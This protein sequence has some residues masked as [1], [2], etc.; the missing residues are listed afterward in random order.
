MPLLGQHIPALGVIAAYDHEDADCKADLVGLAQAGENVQA[1]VTRKDTAILP[2]REDRGNL[3]DSCQWCMKIETVRLQTG[4]VCNDHEL[5]QVR[6]SP[7]RENGNGLVSGRQNL[8]GAP[9]IQRPM[10]F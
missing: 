6:Y 3:I 1:S 2:L 9:F 4:G 5:A 8:F 7:L 10:V